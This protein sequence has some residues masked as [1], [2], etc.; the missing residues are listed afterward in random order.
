MF[1][2]N[3]FLVRLYNFGDNFVQQYLLN[4][5]NAF[6][7]DDLESWLCYMKVYDKE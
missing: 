5:I 3:D 1:L 2:G 4:W 6:L 7:K